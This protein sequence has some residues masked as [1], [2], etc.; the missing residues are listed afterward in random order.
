VIDFSLCAY[1][2]MSKHFHLLLKIDR[3]PTAGILQSHIVR[4]IC[5]VGLAT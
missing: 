1:I 2:L 5:A 3:F 4:H